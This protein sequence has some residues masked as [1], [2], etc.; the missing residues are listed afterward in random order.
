[1]LSQAHTYHPFKLCDMSFSATLFGT[2]GNW[3]LSQLKDPAAEEYRRRL[4]QVLLDLQVGR[5]FATDTTTFNAR[6][7]EPGEFDYRVRVG[8]HMLL[9]APDLPADGTSLLPGE[10][11]VNSPA[12]CLVFVAARPGQPPWVAHGGRWCFI[13]QHEVKYG[14]PD[15]SRRDYSIVYAVMEKL[16]ARRPDEV[17]EIEVAVFWS[18]PA[19]RFPHDRDDEKYGEL[20][21]SL[22]DHLCH[23]GM[24]DC[25]LERGSVFYPDLP[26]I[27]VHQFAARGVPIKNIDLTRAYLPPQGA[28]L[29]GSKGAPRNLAI[30][31][32]RS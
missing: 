4:G 27:L 17:A 10:A 11:V 15:E 9:R 7:I 21:Q 24:Q 13:D 1:M 26:R 23:A 2:P 25:M 5:A 32:R 30:I 22:Y 31:R 12:G 20:N 16:R 8:N 3:S 14:S 28:H 29:D 19:Q 18:I 6:L